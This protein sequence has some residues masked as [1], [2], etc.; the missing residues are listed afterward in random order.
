MIRNHACGRYVIFHGVWLHRFHK[1]KGFEMSLCKSLLMGYESNLPQAC[2]SLYFFKEY[3]EKCDGLIWGHH[4]KH[5]KDRSPEKH[6]K[7]CKANFVSQQL[8]SNQH[9]TR[10]IVPDDEVALEPTKTEKIQVNPKSKI[11]IQNSKLYSFHLL[12][13]QHN[14]HGSKRPLFLRLQIV[15]NRPPN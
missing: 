11:Y 8:K 2:F 6:T 7:T 1:A 10:E 12:S 9:H 13:R 15:Q 4:S 3:H 5:W 14:F